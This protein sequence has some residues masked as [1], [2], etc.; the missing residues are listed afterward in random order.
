MSTS[1]AELTLIMR[2][3]NLASGELEKL[4]SGLDTVVGKAQA[5]GHALAGMAGTLGQG[6]GNLVQA[7]LSGQD[8]GQAFA[9]A[10]INGAGILVGTFGEQI[11]S[12]LAGS[13][14]V[15]GIAATLAGLGST[16]GGLISAAIPIGM[17]AAPALLVA[18]LVAA[19]AFLVTHPEVAGKALQVGGAILGGIL[20]GIAGLVGGLLGVFVNA[21]AGVNTAINT[22]IAG[23]VGFFLS[24]PGSLVNLGASIVTTIIG[25]L[26]SL[27]GRLADV[28]RQAFAGLKIDV[29][30]FHVSA[31][32]VTIDLPTF[33][34]GGTATSG[35]GGA[36]GPPPS[37]G[38]YTSHA[39]GGWVGLN[40]P[41]LSWVGE[42][43]PEYIV[44]NHELG[45]GGP[46]LPPVQ[47]IVDGRV[48]A[49]IV[50]E[51]TYR[52]GQRV[53]IRLG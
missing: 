25:G 7:V 21:F 15:Q 35:R 49:E 53:P 31:A 5:A 36:Y 9:Q 42:R 1:E 10:G 11:L 20:S 41:E 12:K 29:G 27:P 14:I 47:L 2:A 8:V 45:K 44:P 30:P 16:I 6:I 17:A 26:V 19:V 34:S 46:G 13:A 40:G 50:D 4:H 51:H 18:A 23:V 3:R 43:G 38:P 37:S 52:T 39:S 24:I 33:D 28:V 22:F 48:L 32:G